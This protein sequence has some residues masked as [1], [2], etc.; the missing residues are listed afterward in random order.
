[1]C[2]GFQQRLRQLRL[3]KGVSQQVVADFCR[4]SKSTVANYER[5]RRSPSFETAAA[6]ADYFEV[7][8]DYLSGKKEK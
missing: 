2:N 8:L 4:L 5:G 1:M 6:L 3:K 7:S